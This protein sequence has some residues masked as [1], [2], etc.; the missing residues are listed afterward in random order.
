MVSNGKTFT[1]S[2]A[3]E[4]QLV[5]VGSVDYWTSAQHIRSLY[6]QDTQHSP[7]YRPRVVL[8]FQ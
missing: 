2:D 6:N 5:F 1:R 7:T 8:P 3:Q 4:P